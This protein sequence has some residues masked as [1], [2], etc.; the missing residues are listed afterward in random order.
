MLA[1]GRSVAVARRLA[2][3]NGLVEGRATTARRVR[4]VRTIGKRQ[5]KRKA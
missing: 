3:E 5:E 1:A 2:G 4:R